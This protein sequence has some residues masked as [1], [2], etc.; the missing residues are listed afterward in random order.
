MK[1]RRTLVVRYPLS[2]LGK[3][4][5]EAVLKL[6][7]RLDALGNLYA[8]GYKIEPPDVPRRFV[9]EFQYF[10][11]ELAFSTP[12][13]RWLV[14]IHPLLNCQI[15]L[16]NEK[17]RSEGVFIDLPKGVVKVRG[18]IHRRAIEIPLTKSA[19]KYIRERVEESAKVKLVHVWADDGHLYVAITFEREVEVKQDV[20]AVLA[21]DVNSWRNGVSWALI[22]DRKVASRGV[23]RPNLRYVESL[24]NDV[25][26]LEQKL[27]RLERLGLKGSKEYARLWKQAKAKRSKLYRYLRDFVDKLTHRLVKKAVKHSVK[28]VIDDVIEESRR[29]LLEEKLSNGLAKLYLAYIRRFVKLLTNQARWYGLPVEFRRLPSTVCPV[30]NGQLEQKGGRFM[31]C[32]NCRFSANRDEVPLHWA[33]LLYFTILRPNESG[34][35]RLNYHDDVPTTKAT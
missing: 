23:E 11:E 28:V 17:D 13:K 15:R 26:R 19:T 4:E 5:R 2:K 14:H 9:Y 1:I 35:S 8:R 27:G 21:V 6:M 12:P 32:P 25:V 30:C 16:D 24:Y 31:V 20:S 33:K 3:E 29:E 34:Q 10:Q 22:K 7:P 18:F